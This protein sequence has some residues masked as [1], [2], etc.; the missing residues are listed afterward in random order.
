[1]SFLCTS[2]WVCR[3]QGE[4]ASRERENKREKD[5]LENLGEVSQLLLI[6]GYCSYT[7]VAWK[8]RETEEEGGVNDQ[9]K[10]LGPSRL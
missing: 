2:F 6:R 8:A 3:L 4:E 5:R 7:S 9:A 1:V 10:M